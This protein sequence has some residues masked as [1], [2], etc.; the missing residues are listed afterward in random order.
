[1]KGWGGKG[2]GGGQSYDSNYKVDES[3]GLV[4]DFLGT[5]KSFAESTGYG[6][7]ECPEIKKSYNAD[8]FLHKAMKKGYQVGNKIRFTCVLNKDGKPQAKDLKSGLKDADGL[9]TATAS[10]TSPLPVGRM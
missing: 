1:M 8:V 2:W 7:I 5:I 9:T 4:G 3:G 10:I 6:F